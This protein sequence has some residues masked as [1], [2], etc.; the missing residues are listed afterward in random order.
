MRQWNTHESHILIHCMQSI[1]TRPVVEKHMVI[2]KQN[3]IQHI[4]HRERTYSRLWSF[5][6]RHLTYTYH[7]A[8]YDTPLQ[9]ARLV[10]TGASKDSGIISNHLY[11]GR[12]HDLAVIPASRIRYKIREASRI[13]G[14]CLPYITNILS[15]GKAQAS[16]YSHKSK[17][18]RKEL[19][20]SIKANQFERGKWVTDPLDNKDSSVFL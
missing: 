5:P 9:T 19:Q 17:N 18:V 7:C 20:R 11:F 2:E 8:S 13:H 12:S 4:C 3:R 15:R 14:W 1:S 16:I 10:P 6:L